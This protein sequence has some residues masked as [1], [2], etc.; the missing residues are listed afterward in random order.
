MDEAKA[1]SDLDGALGAITL[2]EKAGEHK[3]AARLLKE[4]PEP[5]ADCV[6]EYR[7]AK[8]LLDGDIELEER[9]RGAEDPEQVLYR[10]HNKKRQEAIETVMERLEVEETDRGVIVSDPISKMKRRVATSEDWAGDMDIHKQTM[11]EEIIR[12]D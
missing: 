4:L 2:G 12:N 7:A 10:L 1:S 3:V 11:A 6:R 5:E 9:Y 8:T